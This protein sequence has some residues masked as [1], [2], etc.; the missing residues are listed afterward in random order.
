MR[1]RGENSR[2]QYDG[3]HNAGIVHI[4]SQSVEAD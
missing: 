3:R 1:G 2:I 4:G